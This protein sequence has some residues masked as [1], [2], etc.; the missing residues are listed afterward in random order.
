MNNDEIYRKCRFCHYWADGKCV[1]EQNFKLDELEVHKFSED[2]VLSEAIT[3]S[4]GDVKF[5][6]FEQAL[7]E[8]K[9][10]Q[11]AVLELLQVLYDEWED[12]KVNLV[13]R[14]D[15]CVS[16]VLNNFDLGEQVCVKISEPSEFSCSNFF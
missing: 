16:V 3:E 9:L 2:G 8:S 11:K 14:I 5:S 13:E 7:R 12:I 6:D 1:N 10:S 15:E 4:I